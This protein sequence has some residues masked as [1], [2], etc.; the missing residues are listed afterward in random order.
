VH[1]GEAR[2]R[3][4]ARRKVVGRK[5]ATRRLV[6]EQSG[7]GQTCRVRFRGVRR[8]APVCLLGGG[9]L[10]VGRLGS[11]ELDHAV[12]GRPHGVHGPFVG[13]GRA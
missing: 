8:G 3:A 10:I 12:L 6:M 9:G 11:G 2:R 4:R 1:V 13:S 5:R 7:G